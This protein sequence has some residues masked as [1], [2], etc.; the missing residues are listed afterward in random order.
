MSKSSSVSSIKSDRLSLER[1]INTTDASIKAGSDVINGLRNNP[2]TLPTKYLYDD[3]GSQLFEKICTLPEYYPTRTETT[4]LQN[5]AAEI[6]L[7]TGS[8]EL[9]ELGSGSALKT[10]ILLDAYRNLNYPLRYLPI[11][12]SAG[13]LE[14][15]AFELLVDYP[16]L[17][18]H[19][20]VGTYEL[21]LE[22]LTRPH[23]PTRMLC[24][25][26][27]TLGNLK[28][29]ECQLFFTQISDALQV[30]EYFLLGVDLHKSKAL[31]EPAYNDSQG[32]TAEFSLNMLRHLNH[33]FDG[34]FDLEQF[35]HVSFYNETAHQIEIYLRSKKTQTVNLRSLDLVVNFTSGE[36]IF[37]EISRKFDLAQLEQ[38]LASKGLQ[39]IKVWTD[40]NNWFGLLL[41]QLQSSK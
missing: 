3:H 9:V 11:D 40:P 34:N 19:G 23:L 30:G 6:A 14:S 31:L 27:S 2:K 25:L 12:I 37:T 39:K 17:E 29:Q 18:V 35:E 33:K 20:L 7:T 13:I 26:G 36:T 41:C 1:L 5:C 22:R 10:R 8:C 32:V 21:A 4:I 28:P 15:S 38:E 24:F 16:T